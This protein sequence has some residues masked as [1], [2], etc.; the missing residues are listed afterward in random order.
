MQLKILW[1]IQGPVEAS[2]RPSLIPRSNIALDLHRY[3]CSSQELLYQSLKFAQVPVSLRNGNVRPQQMWKKIMTNTLRVPKNQDPR[4]IVFAFFRFKATT[5]SQLTAY[6]H[7]IIAQSGYKYIYIHQG[8]S[9][10]L[11][12]PTP[13]ISFSLLASNT[14]LN[15]CSPRCLIISASFLDTLK[16]GG[17]AATS[18]FLKEVIR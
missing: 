17:A 1:N 15:E 7:H 8:L 11:C 18:D 16:L 4:D 5:I 10:T 3:G 12:F 13:L 9:S 2:F 14:W 6:L